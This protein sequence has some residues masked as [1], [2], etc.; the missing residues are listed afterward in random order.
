MVKPGESLEL[1][2]AQKYYGIALSIWT[3]RQAE[4]KEAQRALNRAQAAAKE[5]FEERD[6]ALAFLHKVEHRL[7]V[8]EIDQE[9]Q[10]VTPLN[11]VTPTKRKS[12]TPTSAAA[13]TGNHLAANAISQEES[14]V[15]DP[16]VLKRQRQQPETN[17]NDD[18]VVVDTESEDDEDDDYTE[19][20]P[21]APVSPVIQR[22]NSNN[23]DDN[24]NRK[25]PTSSSSSSDN[26]GNNNTSSIIDSLD[27]IPNFYDFLVNVPHGRNQ[28]TV[29]AANAR[30]VI[31][32]VEKLATG[33]GIT[34]LHWPRGTVFA[35]GERIDYNHNNL[36]RLYERAQ[37]F[38]KDY[39]KDKGNG[40]LLRHP[41]K[42]L[43]IYQ[44]YRLFR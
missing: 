27:W 7:E 22:N 24:S 32:Q 3:C 28:K 41:I 36:Q 6:K 31:R 43:Q 25:S 29:T 34:Y 39:G 40:W 42:K 37:Q 19:S 21:A 23:H 1:E 44:E 26:I 20:Q 11:V 14:V 5:A 13:T 15:E 38:E 30:T 10:D 12:P 17:A 35:S 16:R 4:L 33:E 8:I 9:V 2:G 18:T